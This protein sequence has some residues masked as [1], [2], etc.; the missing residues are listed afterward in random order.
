MQRLYFN[1]E[2]GDVRLVPDASCPS[3]EDETSFPNALVPDDVTMEM[4]SFKFA[5]GRIEPDIHFPKIPI[6]T[7]AG[8]SGTTSRD[9]T[10]P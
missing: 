3:M 9:T 5:N 1:F 6:A 4:V 2:T 7:P 8:P 10:T